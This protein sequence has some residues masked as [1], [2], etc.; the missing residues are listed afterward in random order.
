VRFFGFFGIWFRLVG[1]RGGQMVLSFW[2]LV[3]SC[4]GAGGGE[5]ECRK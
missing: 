3:F 2:F 1:V 4:S 5:R